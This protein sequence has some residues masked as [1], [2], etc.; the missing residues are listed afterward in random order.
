MPTKWVLAATVLIAI[1]P[2]CASVPRKATTERLPRFSGATLLVGFPPDNLM[3]TTGEKTLELQTGGGYGDV[4]PSMSR[5]GR[6]IASARVVEDIAP[7]TRIRQRMMPIVYST[8]DQKWTD[9]KEFGI[10][11]GSVA[12][13]PDGAK[14]ACITSEA[15]GAPS[16]LSILDLRTRKKL[17]LPEDSHGAQLGLSWSPDGRRILFEKPSQVSNPGSTPN[18]YLLDVAAGTVTKI[19]EGRSAS[20]SPSGRWIAFYESLSN[21]VS[22]MR[23]DGTGRM[24]LGSFDK[25]EQLAVGPVWSPDSQVLLISKFRDDNNARVD[26]YALDLASKKMTK[27]F[28]DVPPIYAWAPAE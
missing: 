3:T 16:Q 22:I 26:V 12:I 19:A 7:G 27:K 5:G 4:E 15:S 17:A 25:D 18:V 14:L 8:A 10:F 2:E 9:Y 21:R 11:G 6:L 13:S 24:V 1:N 28:K 23:P 20:W